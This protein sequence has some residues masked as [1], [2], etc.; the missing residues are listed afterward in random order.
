MLKILRPGRHRTSPPGR[1]R[2][3]APPTTTSSS[4]TCWHRATTPRW[5]PSP[6]G[7]EIRRQPQHQR[8]V[9]QRPAGR[10]GDAARRRRRHHRQ[11]RPRLRRRHAGPPQ[12][13]RRRHPHRRP[14][15]AR[16]HVDHRGQQDAAGQHLAVRA[17]R[18]AD[19]LIGPSGAGK[20]TFARLVAGYTHP[21]HGHGD[22]RRPR[23]P[24]RVRLAALQNRDGAA[25]RRRARSADRPAGADVRRRTAT[26]ARHQQG[27]PRTGRHTRCSRNSR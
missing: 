4:P 1:S 12:R 13:D 3:V 16:R 21:T 19:R 6:G 5:C 14:R 18:H 10:L 2:S 26:A 8:H 24:R 22:V 11:H 9:R 15:R 27:R 23:R 20:S 25:G 7:T 17:T